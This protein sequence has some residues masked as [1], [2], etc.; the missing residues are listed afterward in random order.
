M[1][2]PTR[3]ST[4]ILSIFLLALAALVYYLLVIIE[5]PA[6]QKAIEEKKAQSPS[7]TGA[8]TSTGGGNT[9]IPPSVTPQAIDPANAAVAEE[10]HNAS[11]PPQRDLEVIEHF[12]EIY[13]KA[14]GGNPVGLNE[15]ITDVLTGGGDPRRPRLYPPNNRAVRNGQLVDRWGTPYWFHPNNATQMEIRSA[16][17]DKQMFTTDDIVKNP[18]PQGFGA[19]PTVGSIE[20]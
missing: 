7:I 8:A 12:L 17:A 15:D 16:G 2:L 3:P 6:L 9:R 10:M 19:T 11:A 20:R 1:K 14:T 4:Y 5:N 18:S 13:R